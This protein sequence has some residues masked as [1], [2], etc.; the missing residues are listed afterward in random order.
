MS[1]MQA[2]YTRISATRRPPN[3]YLKALA[4]LTSMRLELLKSL[5]GDLGWQ[6]WGE[7]S[8]PELRS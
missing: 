7:Q 8:L 1:T 4:A 5:V 3:A 2:F 6:Q